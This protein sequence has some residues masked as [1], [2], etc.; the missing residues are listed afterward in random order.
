MK[1]QLAMPPPIMT[2]RA[3]SPETRP[4]FASW[5]RVPV[6][7]GIEV[8]AAIEVVA[9]DEDVRGGIEVVCEDGNAVELNGELV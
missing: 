5:L 9:L 8:A 2:I 6:L 1:I 4:M 7:D 3:L